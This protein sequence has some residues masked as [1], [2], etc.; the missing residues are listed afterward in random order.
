MNQLDPETVYEPYLFF[1][2]QEPRLRDMQIWHSLTL[3]LPLLLSFDLIVSVMVDF[4]SA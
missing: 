3:L 2:I 1:Y 4:E